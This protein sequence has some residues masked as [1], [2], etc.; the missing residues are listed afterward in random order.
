[1]LVLTAF[2]LIA[3]SAVYMASLYRLTLSEKSSRRSLFTILLVNL[4]FL[5]PVLNGPEDLA[6]RA[7]AC[8]IVSFGALISFSAGKSCLPFPLLREASIRGQICR[9]ALLILVLFISGAVSGNL[10][11]DRSDS[12]GLFFALALLPTLVEIGHVAGAEVVVSAG[13]TAMQ[14]PLM[15]L[16]AAASGL[17][18]IIA[19]AMCIAERPV[20]SAPER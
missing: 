17:L 11:F 9:I 7:F 15:I 6:W 12:I 14:A 5:A 1:M 20:F 3:G 19:I 10:F 8:S 16:P 18:S 4:S 2:V 13:D